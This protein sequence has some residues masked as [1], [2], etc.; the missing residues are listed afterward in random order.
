MQGTPLQPLREYG[1]SPWVHGL[2]SGS[3]LEQLVR[4]HGIRGARLSQG[5]PIAEIQ[6]ACEVLGPVWEES[7]GEDGYVSAPADPD[8]VDR[9]NFMAEIADLSAIEDAVAA[10]IPVN[11]TQICS[12]SRYDEVVEAYMRGI[13]R[14]VASGEDPASVT[15][16]ASFEVSAVDAEVDRLLAALDRQAARLSGRLGVANARLAYQA[17]KRAFGERRWHSLAARGARPQRCSWASTSR[18]NP[19]YCDVTYVEE[20]IGPETVTTLTPSTIQAFEDHGVAADKLERGIDEARALFE[21]IRD[22]GVDLRQVWRAVCE[23]R[24]VPCDQ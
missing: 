8:Q 23:P 16:I 10:G 15:S 17:Y 6:D 21:E 12:L 20:L 14:F 22:L 9:P 18:S 7:A 13:E 1:Q 4:T 3:E 24:G 2:V 19:A 11:A 5:L